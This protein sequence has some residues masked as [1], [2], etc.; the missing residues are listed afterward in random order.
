MRAAVQCIEGS[1]ASD[2]VSYLRFW[3]RNPL[4]DDMDGG[5]GPAAGTDESED[6]MQHSPVSTGSPIPD[7]LPSS[8]IGGF[9]IGGNAPNQLEAVVNCASDG[10]IVVLRRAAAPAPVHLQGSGHPVYVNS[11]RPSSSRNMLCPG[12]SPNFAETSYQQLAL[13]TSVPEAAASGMGG[14]HVT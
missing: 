7:S 14:R 6:D 11:S 5:K 2:T 1:K 3:F 8:P 4:E 12:N 13:V 9:P 10:I